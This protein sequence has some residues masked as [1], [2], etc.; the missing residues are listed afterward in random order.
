MRQEGNLVDR[1]EDLDLTMGPNTE[2]VILR[3]EGTGSLLTRVTKMV[4][5]EIIPILT[6]T[7]SIPSITTLRAGETDPMAITKEVAVFPTVNN[8]RHV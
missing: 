4:E 6:N 7:R 3:S 2:V 1:Q 5:M 8:A